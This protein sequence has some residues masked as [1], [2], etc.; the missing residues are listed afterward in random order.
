MWFQHIRRRALWTYVIAFL[1]TVFLVSL[2]N[3]GNANSRFLHISRARLKTLQSRYDPH[4]DRAEWALEIGDI[5]LARYTSDMRRAWR[6]IFGTERAPWYSLWR[7]ASFPI[8]LDL[9]MSRLQ[10]DNIPS[11]DASI[12]HRV[13]TTSNYPPEKYPPQFRYWAQNDKRYDHLFFRPL[14][15]IKL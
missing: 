11:F 1:F 8:P 13:Y 2:N 7:K 9:V 4:R 6:T 15:S 5:D 14:S 10:L 12:P 3:R